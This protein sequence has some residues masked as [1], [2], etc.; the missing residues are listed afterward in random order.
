MV[1]ISSLCVQRVSKFFTQNILAKRRSSPSLQTYIITIFARLKLILCILLNLASECPN[2]THFKCQNGQCVPIEKRCNDKYDCWD[3]TDEINC[4]KLTLQVLVT[5]TA[6]KQN[7]TPILCRTHIIVSNTHGTVH[8]ENSLSCSCLLLHP[9]F[10]TPTL[11]QPNSD[12]YCTKK[13]A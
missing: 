10:Y 2:D 1:E 6:Q 12:Q 7:G 9:F 11:I 3:L 13:I 8:L 4:R 5:F